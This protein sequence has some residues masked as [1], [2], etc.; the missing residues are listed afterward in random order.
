[1]TERNKKEIRFPIQQQA[2]IEPTQPKIQC[3]ESAFNTPSVKYFRLSM[4]VL[5]AVQRQIRTL[6][7]Y[8]VFKNVEC[9][10]LNVPPLLKRRKHL[11]R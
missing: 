5:R 1:M 6:L 4:T 7:T 10:S 2:E 9:S 8:A 3:G 11:L